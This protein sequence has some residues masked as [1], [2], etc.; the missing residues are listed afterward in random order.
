MDPDSTTFCLTLIVVYLLLKA[1]QAVGENA[2]LYCSASRLERLGEEGDKRALRL[3]ALLEEP[4]RFLSAIG[5][6][7]TFFGV[8]AAFETMSLFLPKVTAALDFLP[9]GLKGQRLCA[10]ILLGLGM[11]FVSMILGTLLPKRLTA[12]KAE[13]KALQ[14]S[15]VLHTIYRI[16]KPFAAL[17]SG[18]TNL[19]LRAMGM[20]PDAQ[21]E[22]VTEEEIR[23]MVD[24]GNEEGT[25]EQSEK[26]MINNIFEFDEK[27]V[28]EVMTHRTEMVAVE[29]TAT[30][31]EVAKVA[32]EEGF[33]RI[34]VYREDIDDIVGVIYAKDLLKYVED[35]CNEN[36]SIER[37]VREVL[38]VPESNRC[39]ELFKT[40]NAKKIQMA[41]VVDEYGGTSG[42]VTMEDLLEAIVGN[43]QDEY[44]DEEE[45]VCKISDTEYILDGSL[46]IEDV[47]KA[48][49][50]DLDDE[51]EEYDTLG[52]LI[53]DVLDRIPGENEHPHVMLKNVKLSVLLVKERRIKKVRA[54]L[55]EPA[56]D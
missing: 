56:E 28:E 40:F 33:S 10:L 45:E 6:G 37:F 13:E 51:A 1:A 43:M 44:D 52:G 22:Q 5:A 48:L 42:V 26:D 29:S 46:S 39:T 34:P 7:A 11:T 30:V 23:M 32:M 4:D 36:E 19:I 50:V 24:V 27:T 38:F 18:V 47:A 20:D 16:C 54:E 9:L 41:I 55:L 25:I 17:L 3:S 2:A 49:D 35:P 53:T 12:M 21:P 31:F 15:G 14:L 8:L